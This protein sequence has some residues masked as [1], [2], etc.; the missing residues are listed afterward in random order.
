MRR[1]RCSCRRTTRPRSAAG[2]A[3]WTAGPARGRLQGRVGMPWLRGLGTGQGGHPHM[4][5]PATAPSRRCH[6]RTLPP[7]PPPPRGPPLAV[8]PPGRCHSGWVAQPA[9]L[10]RCHHGAVTPPPP[11]RLPGLPDP[12]LPAGRLKVA[13]AASRP[14]EARAAASGSAH[15][16]PSCWS[17][18]ASSRSLS[19]HLRVPSAVRDPRS[20]RLPSSAVACGF[21]QPARAPHACMPGCPP[22]WHQ[23]RTQ[24]LG[25]TASSTC[26]AS[27]A[28][29]RPRSATRRSAAWPRRAPPAAPPMPPGAACAAIDRAAAVTGPPVP[30]LLP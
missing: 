11:G 20:Y 18:Q 9:L 2:A 23:P 1:R 30:W 29:C 5:T 22:P 14:M 8:L 7:P 12:D 16:N 13:P 19:S 28:W 6:W 17:S 21:G 26:P 10:E 3:A 4:R 25:G 27:S 15:M 24:T